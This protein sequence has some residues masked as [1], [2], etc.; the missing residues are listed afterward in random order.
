MLT[1]LAA[2]AQNLDELHDSVLA[3]LR[4]HPAFFLAVLAVLNVF[5][6]AG[7]CARRK[8]DHISSTFWRKALRDADLRQTLVPRYPGTRAVSRDVSDTE[9][10]HE[11]HAV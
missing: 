3:L 8:I 11:T 1:Q 5:Y 7:G 6:V 10:P 4:D 2:S 9:A